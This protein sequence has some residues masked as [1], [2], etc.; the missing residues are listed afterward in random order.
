MQLTKNSITSVQKRSK[1]FPCNRRKFKIRFRLK[2]LCCCLVM[3][4]EQRDL[5]EVKRNKNVAWYKSR[6]IYSVRLLKQ[7]RNIIVV[8]DGFTQRLHETF[9]R[10]VHVFRNSSKR[11]Q[12]QNQRKRAQ[13]H[14][15]YHGRNTRTIFPC[16]CQGARDIC[17][18]C[19]HIA[20]DASSIGNRVTYFFNFF[21][22]ETHGCQ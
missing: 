19:M 9:K 13:V 2:K 21:Q 6:P 22:T 4:F 7:Q 18:Y 16:L 14:I 3:Q 20:R 8:C 15:Y 1:N 12:I 17:T 11:F 5:T 10:N